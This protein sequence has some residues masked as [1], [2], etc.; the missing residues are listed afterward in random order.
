[1]RSRPDNNVIGCCYYD[2]RVGPRFR[3]YTLIPLTIF[4]LQYMPN[5]SGIPL[6]LEMG[7]L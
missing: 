3:D 6:T 4:H 2:D 1:M 7:F 5:I